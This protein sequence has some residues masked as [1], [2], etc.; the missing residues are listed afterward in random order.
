ME[1]P[2]RPPRKPLLS[3]RLSAR[4]LAGASAAIGLLIVAS[5]AFTL[6]DSDS[7]E[8]PLTV[9]PA[10]PVTGNGSSGGSVTG[11]PSPM[12][13]EDAAVG[14]SDVYRGGGISYPMPLPAPAFGAA[15]I[16]VSG[17]GAV[18]AVPDRISWSFTVQAN[19]L[20]AHAALRRVGELQQAIVEALKDSGAEEQQI[21]TQSI[22][23]YP[24]F[25]YEAQ[26]VQGYD[27]SSSIT[28]TTGA[29]GSGELVGAAVAAGATQ[30]SGPNLSLG[31]TEGLYRQALA[32]AF[33]Q[34]R[35]RA[36]TLAKAGGV[37]LGAPLSVTASENSYSGPPVAY[38]ADAAMEGGKAVTAVQT[39]ESQVTASVSVIFSVR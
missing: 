23:L 39:G 27:A 26:R 21:Q 10:G 22:S 3:S 28:V 9:A 38:A 7:S 6:R 8:P 24:R 16:S 17:S 33:E 13:A 15:G 11:A 35:K 34:A 29:T 31:D 19:E 5:A 32:Q 25:D 18:V 12:P 14:S 36:E 4:R 1:A 30:V 20:S 37:E 2:A